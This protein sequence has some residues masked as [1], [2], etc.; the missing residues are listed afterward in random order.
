[1]T[2][3]VRYAIYYIIIAI[4]SFVFGTLQLTILNIVGENLSKKIRIAV[5]RKF[6]YNEI[7][8]YDLPE[9]A[10]GVL[11]S[12][13]STE[14]GLVN[15]LA[16]TVLGVFVQALSSF[17]TGT[18]IAFIASWQL[19]FVAL[20]LSPLMII[21]GVVQ[22]KFNAGFSA[23][24][25]EV[26]R[27]SVNFVSEAVNNMRTVASFAKEDKLLD[28]FSKKLQGPLKLATRKGNLSGLAFGFSQFGMFF[29]Y[30]VVFFIGAVFTIKIDLGYKDLFLSIFGVLFAAFGAG[31]AMQYAPDAGSAR[32]AAVNIFEIL[33]REP[34]IKID[35]PNQN[36][37]KEI[38]GEIEFR[39][40]WFKYP[41]RPKH[42][43]RGVS[44]KINPSSKVAFVGP[45]GCGKS[46]IMSLLLRFYDVEKG[47]IFIDGVEIRNYDLRHLRLH[48]GVVSQ[49]PTLFNGTIDYNIRYSKENATA[50][51]VRQAA[52]EANALSFIERNEFDDNINQN[53]GQKGGES[54]FQRKVGP[55]GSQISGG[56][57]Q[58]I[59][60]ARAI[61]NKPPVL[62]LDEATSALDAQSEKVVQGSLDKIMH[63]KTAIVIA[64]RISTIRDAD[65]ILVFNE[66]QVAEKGTYEELIK[67]QGMFYKL[68]K[69][70]AL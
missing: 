13:L 18:V 66:G 12:R 20:G 27:E 36:V 64:H 69:G 9:N 35:A 26:Y 45:S 62:L 53:G 57:K 31:N 5:F 19:T 44:F 32:T 65:E 61:M 22:A 47:E 55:K 29:V 54:G 39:N 38:K 4:A 48:F 6:L 2:K 67:A 7:G 3:S 46:T 68:E 42:I 25:D 15:S 16:S 8:W 34:L 50:E 28:N 60:I 49:E 59:A 52:A 10:P 70:I 14:S 33:D 58:R 23:E 1:M 11:I 37:R 41:T 56:Q 63:G 30:A 51:E 40:V 43:L 24:T 17:I 21:S